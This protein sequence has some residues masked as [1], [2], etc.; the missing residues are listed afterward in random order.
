MMTMKKPGNSTKSGTVL[1][2]IDAFLSKAAA[3]NHARFGLVTNNAAQTSTGKPGS[4]ALL[5]DGYKIT[6]LFSPEHGHSVQG[7]DGVYQSNSVDQ[8]TQLPINSLYGDH[9]IPTDADLAELDIVLFDLPDAGCRFYTYLWTMTYVMEA[10]AHHNK[11]LII[12]DRP[13]PIGGDIQLAEGPMLDEKNCSSF[14]GRWNIPVRHSCTLGEL[15]RY[16]TAT[17]I[18]DLN[19]EVI[20]VQ[21]WNRKQTVTE[22]GWQFVPTSPAIRDAE[23]ALLYPGMGLLE[24]INVNEGRGT[25]SPF[26]QFGAPWIDAQ[27]LH[28]AFTGLRLPG[29]KSEPVSYIPEGGYYSGEICHGLQFSLIDKYTFQPVKTGFSLLQLLKNLYPATCE[30]RHYHTVA[31][32]LGSGHLD[33]LTGTYRSFE[34]INT[35]DLLLASGG[36]TDPVWMSWKKVIGPYLLY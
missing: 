8:L 34:K 32:P 18:K 6:R 24:G 9:F 19:L 7:E 10:C 11:P 33:K 5:Q 17:R 36:E 12:L 25:A 15:A 16:F 20:P 30:E 4:L 13:N 35:A 1:F 21:N 14:I 31:N 26:K 28:M 29:I 23:T 22:A 2:G 3:Y 27:Q